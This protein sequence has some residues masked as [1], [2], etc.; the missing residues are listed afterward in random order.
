LRTSFVQLP[1]DPSDD[2]LDDLSESPKIL[3]ERL[4]GR[5]ILLLWLPALC[6]LAG[7]TVRGLFSY[8]ARPEL[9]TSV[10][11]GLCSS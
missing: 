6:D 3:P 2:T 7:T 10:R 11:L 8:C 5:R 4:T 9:L 1:D